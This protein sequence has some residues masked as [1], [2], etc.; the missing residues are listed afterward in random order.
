MEKTIS[1]SEE[2]IKL[3]KEYEVD[4][5]SIPEIT[6]FEQACEFRKMDP[7]TC[8]PDIS[9]FPADHQQ[10]LTATAKMYIIAEALNQDADGECWKPDWNNGDERKWLPWFDMEVDKNN[11]SGFR[12]VG[13]Y[14][15]VVA[16]GSTGGS[17]LC[18]RNS[19]I[20]G[21]AGK[22]FLSLYKEMMVFSK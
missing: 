7:T 19:D 17:R 18:Y 2:F 14:C 10:A 1:K 12:F 11:P 15:D 4:P 5:D 20:S 13:S 9:M 3:C 6:S 22:H 21:F 16:A 8:L